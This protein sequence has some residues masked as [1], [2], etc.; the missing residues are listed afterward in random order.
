M[1]CV[2]FFF[3]CPLQQGHSPAY[4]RDHPQDIRHRTVQSRRPPPVTTHLIKGDPDSA[5]SPSKYINQLPD[6]IKL[7]HDEPNEQIINLDQEIESAIQDIHSEDNNTK[8]NFRTLSTSSSDRNNA[9]DSENKTKYQKTPVPPRRKKLRKKKKRESG[10]S[11]VRFGRG[12]ENDEEEKKKK[13]AKQVM[14]E[15]E[16]LEQLNNDVKKPLTG[17]EE[18]ID[19]S[20]SATVSKFEIEK[21]LHKSKMEMG[22]ADIRKAI[23]NAHMFGQKEEKSHK[24]RDEDLKSSTSRV[25]HYRQLKPSVPPPTSNKTDSLSK[26]PP[27]GKKVPPNVSKDKDEIRKTTKKTP[28]KPLPNPTQLGPINR[29]TKK[30]LSDDQESE[31]NS[32]RL[33]LIK[34]AREARKTVKTIP[35]GSDSPSKPNPHSSNKASLPLMTKPLPKKKGAKGSAD[36]ADA[37]QDFYRDFR[38]IFVT[39]PHTE[40]ELP[41]E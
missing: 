8:V 13:E 27:V 17:Q 34:A 6:V 2:C 32:K 28:P 14:G 1:N 40:D 5:T 7:V 9:K 3:H 11:P 38:I 33:E 21:F 29:A 4:Y 36:Y 35:M 20:T 41:R 10:S 22:E 31:E 26:P 16:D 18:E 37:D 19:F 15:I 24:K 23:K 25:A 12:D 39:L 30:S